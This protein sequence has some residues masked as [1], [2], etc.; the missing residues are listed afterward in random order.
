MKKNILTNTFAIA[1]ISSGVFAATN[2]LTLKNLNK[3]YAGETNASYKYAIYAQKADE[4]GYPQ[5][6]KLFRAIS[7]AESIHRNNHEAA[8]LSL[9]GKPDVI[10]YTKVLAATTKENLQKP[11]KDESYEFE[12]MYPEFIKQAKTDKAEEAVKSFTYAYNTE[13]E[14]YQLLENA[15]RNLNSKTN[16]DYCVSKVSGDT[17]AVSASQS[18]AN[19][20]Y[21]RIH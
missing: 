19:E 10:E 15:L 11:L 5:A 13:K 1:L 8:I 6:G 20:E 21:I 14:H 18:C 9:G 17:S 7:M 12:A 3:A 4:E 2:D 16:I